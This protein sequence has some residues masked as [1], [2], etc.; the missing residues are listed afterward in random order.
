M[1]IYRDDAIVEL[2][3]DEASNFSRDGMAFDEVLKAANH[4][5][6]T[7]GRTV[8]IWS[9][10]IELGFYDAEKDIYCPCASAALPLPMGE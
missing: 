5:S 6:D 2:S 10:T 9:P 7:T 1:K 8:A 3:E 4:L